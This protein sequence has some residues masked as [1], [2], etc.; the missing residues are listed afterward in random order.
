MGKQDRYDFGGADDPL[1]DDSEQSS[2]STEAEPESS[3]DAAATTGDTADAGGTGVSST[4]PLT[5]ES[6]SHT[7]A[8]VVPPSTPEPSE[9]MDSSN[10]IPHRV[11]YDS[12]KDARTT[13]TFYLNK[14]RDLARLRDLHS[15]AESEFDEKIHQLDV[16]LAAFRS[17]LSDDSFL[18]EMRSIGYGYFD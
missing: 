5:G 11:R 2:A 1:G 9:F 7:D 16:Y 17:D 13:K 6:D 4:T 10:E 15:L 14:E 12:P 3:D 8:D 18:L